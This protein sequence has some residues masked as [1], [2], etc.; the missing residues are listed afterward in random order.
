MSSVSDPV[1]TIITAPATCL[2]AWR[3]CTDVWGTVTI[4]TYE[5]LTG[6]D[7]LS[8]VDSNTAGRFHINARVLLRLAL[9]MDSKS[10]KQ[11]ELDGAPDC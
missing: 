8:G 1:G 11:V 2:A 10:Q 4:P 5:L 7:L 9:D 3:S 6:R